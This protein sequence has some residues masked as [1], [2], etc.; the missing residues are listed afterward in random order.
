MNTRQSSL[1]RKIQKDVIQAGEYYFRHVQQ[2]PD[3]TNCVMHLI[4]EIVAD[5][6]NFSPEII[7]KACVWDCVNN[8]DAKNVQL[9]RGFIALCQEG[10]SHRDD[11]VREVYATL[12]RA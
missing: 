5:T 8:T 10:S 9:S 2:N 7:R 4:A 1:R 3:Q 11:A 12:Y 6:A